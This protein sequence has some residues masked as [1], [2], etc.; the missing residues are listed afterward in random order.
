MR[1]VVMEATIDPAAVGQFSAAIG[2][3]DQGTTCLAALALATDPNGVGPLRDAARDVVTAAGLGDV[4][5]SPQQLPFSPLQLQGMVASPLLQAASLVSADNSTWADRSD[6]VLIAQG[7]ASGSTA[8]LFATFVL[9]ELPQ[10]AEGLGQPGARMLDVGTGIGALAVGFAEM[11]PQ[12]HVT[13]IDV[14]D[15]VLDLARA[16]V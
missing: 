16:H 10:L 11:F 8:L 14:M 6:A 12:L 2:Q 7:Q 5:T 13:G 3:W 9:P 4:L 1:E 15:R